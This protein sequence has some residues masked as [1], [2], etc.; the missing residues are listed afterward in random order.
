MEQQKKKGRRRIVSEP[1][2]DGLKH[3]SKNQVVDRGYSQKESGSTVKCAV[4]NVRR[5]QAQLT[6]KQLTDEYASW[7][8]F[9]QTSNVEDDESGN[10][11]AEDCLC[12]DRDN[13]DCPD[14]DTPAKSGEKRKRY[15]NSVSP[16]FAILQCTHTYTHL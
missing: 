12:N 9:Q 10:N 1:Y 16:R 8:P 7:E 4:A 14:L 11:P 5:K 3:D 15:V 6:P 13:A 2:Y